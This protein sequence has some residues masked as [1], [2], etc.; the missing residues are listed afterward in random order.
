[1]LFDD[2]ASGSTTVNLIADVAPRFG[3]SEQHEPSPIRSRAPTALWDDPVHEDR[4]RH[5]HRRDRRTPTAVSPRSAPDSSSSGEQRAARRHRQGQPHRQRHAGPQWLQRRRQWAGAA[6]ERLTTRERPC[7]SHR[8]QR[9]LLQHLRRDAAD[10]GSPLS[11]VKVGTGTLQLTA[12]ARTPGGVTI[13]AGTVEI[14]S[15]AGSRH[16]SYAGRRH[17]GRAGIAHDYQPAGLLG[18]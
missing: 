12:R 16:A 9:Q 4:H 3:H 6:R 17:A 10:S 8:R 1:M 15:G 11:L 2:S 18:E 5:A 14:A 7:R 13:N